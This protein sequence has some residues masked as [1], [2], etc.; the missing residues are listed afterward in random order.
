LSDPAP[1]KKLTLLR[2]AKARPASL[3]PPPPLIFRAL[4]GLFWQP[5]ANTGDAGPGQAAGVQA[6]RLHAGGGFEAAHHFARERLGLLRAVLQQPRS[7]PHRRDV[8]RIEV[9]ALTD[10]RLAADE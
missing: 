8:L 2:L 5:D 6:H 1:G 3:P 9:C 4:H 7:Q 10:V